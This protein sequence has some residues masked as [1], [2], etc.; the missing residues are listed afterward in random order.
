MFGRDEPAESI[1]DLVDYLS[2][3][4][5]PGSFVY[6]GQVREYPG[7]LL[8]SLYRRYER[9]GQTYGVDDPQHRY[10]LRRSGRSLV[11]FFPISGWFIG[12]ALDSL[13]ALPELV[14]SA[15]SHALELVSSTI[16][17]ENSS[18]R[19]FRF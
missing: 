10:S 2:Q 19:F 9:T 12:Q 3:Q 16:Q 18:L 1:I 17:S 11:D 8:P 4:D 14:G 15:S 7:P 6:R 5:G 13:A